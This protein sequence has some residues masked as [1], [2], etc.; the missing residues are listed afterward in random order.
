MSLR[1]T[2]P[3]SRKPKMTSERPVPRSGCTD[4]TGAASRRAASWEVRR[5]QLSSDEVRRAQL[6]AATEWCK[7]PSA[8]RAHM[9]ARSPQDASRW[10][11]RLPFFVVLGRRISSVSLPRREC[12]APRVLTRQAK[13]GVCMQGPP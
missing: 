12:D 11:R 8:T 1:M 6:P 10:L 7:V 2:V 13:P 4:K 9:P 3:A 5:G